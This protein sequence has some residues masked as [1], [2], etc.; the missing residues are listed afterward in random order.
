MRSL[1]H[2]QEAIGS[3]TKSRLFVSPCSSLRHVP[4]IPIDMTK[5]LGFLP[6]SISVLVLSS[7]HEYLISGDGI[8]T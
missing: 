4:S 6:L 2:S 1:Y 7:A 3:G 5:H 8:D